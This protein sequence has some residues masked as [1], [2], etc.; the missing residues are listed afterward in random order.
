MW[1]KMPFIWFLSMVIICFLSLLFCSCSKD[2]KTIEPTPEAT[3]PI[4]QRKAEIVHQL[5]R[6]NRYA[7]TNENPSFSGVVSADTSELPMDTLENVLQENHIDPSS[8]YGYFVAN[9]IGFSYYQIDLAAVVP[10]C[11]TTE[12]EIVC[13]LQNDNKPVLLILLDSADAPSYARYYFCPSWNIA[14]EQITFL[15]D[16]KTPTE[17]ESS[18]CEKLLRI[19]LNTDGLNNEDILDGTITIHK[20]T[21]LFDHYPGLACI[22]RYDQ[23]E[24]HN[25]FYITSWSE[26]K[27]VHVEE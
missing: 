7:I 2:N 10:I 24:K 8:P 27:T 3:I 23:F 13:K 25:G 21:V 17:Q 22:L 26:R 20:I 18:L 5:T 1:K 16:G 15:L 19:N 9:P 4:L 12:G 11:L 14:N 6:T